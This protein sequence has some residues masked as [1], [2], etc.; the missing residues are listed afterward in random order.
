MY[1]V[2]LTR[3]SAKYIAIVHWE[4]PKHERFMY[5]FQGSRLEAGS[6]L[7]RRNRRQICKTMEANLFIQ[8]IPYTHWVTRTQLSSLLHSFVNR[9]ALVCDSSAHMQQMYI[10]HIFNSVNCMEKWFVQPRKHTQ[11]LL[12]CTTLAKPLDRSLNRS[13]SSR[14]PLS[15]RH[16]QL[17]LN[18]ISVQLKCSG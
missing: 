2:F 8:R 1:V 10:S 17:P 13:Y 7:P 4:N 9:N 15:S 6:S 5:I 18:S 3:M 11:L 14:A 12:W 16:K